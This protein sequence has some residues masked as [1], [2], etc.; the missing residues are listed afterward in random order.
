MAKYKENSIA[1]V[2]QNQADKLKS[3][4]C[5]AYKKDGEYTDISWT[6]MKKMVNDLA[7]YLLSIGIKKGDRIGLFSPNRYEWWVADLAIL[8]IGAI[9]VPIYSTNSAEE[10]HYVLSNSE[11]SLCF[12]GTEDHLQKVLK[13]KKKLPKLKHLVAFNNG[14][15]KSKEAVTLS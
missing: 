3:K 7:C 10:T 15:S 2:F 11:S 4:A 12:I 13:V 5:V 8:S 1:A 6:D 14:K 9:N